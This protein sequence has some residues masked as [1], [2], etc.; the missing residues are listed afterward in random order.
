MEKNIMAERVTIYVEDEELL[1]KVRAYSEFYKR[2]LSA[3]IGEL[4]S[5]GIELFDEE[6]QPPITI[7][8]E[9]RKLQETVERDQ[10]EIK[11]IS[12]LLGLLREILAEGRDRF[13]DLEKKLLTSGTPEVS[14]QFFSILHFLKQNKANVLKKKVQPGKK[15]SRG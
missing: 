9:F 1:D 15:G 2:S 5:T 6:F 8:E 3:G 7:L 10:R 14:N 13:A 11:T 12:H 4:L